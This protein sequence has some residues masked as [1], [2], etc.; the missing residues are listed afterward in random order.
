MNRQEKEVVIAEISEKISRAKGLFFADFTGLTVEQANE[1]R[2]EFQKS[3]VDYKVV[4][5][6]LVK[7][8]L[9]NVSGFD[10]V[11]AG[12]RGPTAIAI[13]YDDPISPAKI[14]RKYIDKHEKPSV[15][16]CVVEN[17]VYDGSKLVELSKLPS[18]QELVASIL[19]SLQ[20]PILGV[21]YAV[22]A[23][24]RDLVSVVGAIEDKKKSSA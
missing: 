8:A 13:S 2:R 10:K 5:N 7:K 15:K 4:K 20:S 23:V 9:E 18:R 3:G 14:I 22:Q 24:T 6:T 17:L 21:I 1:L 19:G 12:L 16:V 11:I